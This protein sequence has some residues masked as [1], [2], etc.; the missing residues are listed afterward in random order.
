MLTKCNERLCRLKAGLGLEV[1]P[2]PI[3]EMVIQSV[4]S[5]KYQDGTAVPSPLPPPQ[6]EAAAGE[7][8]APPPPPELSKA[9]KR[10]AKRVKILQEIVD[11]E[12][13]YV[14]SLTK[15]DKVYIT[16]LRLVATRQPP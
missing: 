10:A 13:S 4:K 1:E 9:E 7:A 5:C 14:S 16:P 6:L 8:S 15:L 11:T 12:R 3:P 2:P